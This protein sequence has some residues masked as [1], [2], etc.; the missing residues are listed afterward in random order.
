MCIRQHIVVPKTQDNKILTSQPSITH[1]IMLLLA[2]CMLSTINFDDQSRV[3]ANEVSNIRT[4]WHLS[5]KR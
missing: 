4:Y 5:T 3:E 2:R 1:R